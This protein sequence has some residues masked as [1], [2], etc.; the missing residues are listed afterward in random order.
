[1]LKIWYS[2]FELLNFLDSVMILK[3]WNPFFWVTQFFGLSHDSQTKKSFFLSYSIFWTQSWFSN[4]EIH[5]FELLN[6]LDLVMIDI[7]ILIINEHIHYVQH[8]II[9]WDCYDKKH[10]KTVYPHLITQNK[11]LPLKV[12]K[13]VQ[14][15][16]KEESAETVC[17]L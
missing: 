11:D 5:F 16:L 10:S 6:F 7:E 8:H 4:N 13:V 3:Q 12:L 14:L 2:F 9:Q 17:S 15:G 1:M